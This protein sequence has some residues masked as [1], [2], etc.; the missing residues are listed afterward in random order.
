VGSQP[1][2][3]DRSARPKRHL[4]QNFLIDPNIAR[5]IVAELNP[6]PEDGV[7]EIGPGRGALTGILSRSC[8][9]VLGIEKDPDLALQLKGAFANLGLVVA[10][11][12]SLD[13]TRLV[14]PRWKVIGNLPYNIASPLIW[15]L[16]RQVSPET[17]MVFLVQKEVAQRL[18]AAEGNR[19]FGG[20][21]VWVQS[22]TRARLAFKV[23]PN[24]FRPRPRVES[25]VVVL[26]RVPSGQE[27]RQSADLSR[28]I[29]MCF[30]HRRKQL[31]TILKP[32]WTSEVQEWLET[33]NLGAQV[34]PEQMTVAQ[35]N[36][37]ASLLFS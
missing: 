6:G 15:D 1:A 2:A 22:F 20:L 7:V 21:S 32:L 37:L 36:A 25:A 8:H 31:G 9:S 19:S 13:W 34:R 30:Q 33:Q 3:S 11:A 35:F 23:G 12:L 29:R 17:R 26:D 16:V 4:G 14:R 27:P 5:K 18:T 28:L 10:D 24:V